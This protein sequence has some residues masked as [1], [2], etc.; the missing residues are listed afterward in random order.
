[1]ARTKFMQRIFSA[2]ENKESEVLDQIQKDIEIALEDGSIN[3]EEYDISV[4][5]DKVLLLDK[6]NNETTEIL[7]NAPE[8]YLK[9]YVEEQNDSIPQPESIN[10]TDNSLKINTSVKWVNEL[11]EDQVGILTEI[12]GDLATVNQDGV[13]II[14]PVGI[15]SSVDEY[16][17]QPESKVFA[18]FTDD[19]KLIMR[20]GNYD[21]QLDIDEEIGLVLD[22]NI[23]FT[24]DS[25]APISKAM[26][27]IK[28]QMKKA[29]LKGFSNLSNLSE[30]TRRHLLSQKEFSQKPTQDKIDK[31][32]RQV[33]F[34]YDRRSRLKPNTKLWNQANYMLLLEQARLDKLN[35][36]IIPVE[37][38]TDSQKDQLKRINK[39]IHES[40]ID[41]YESYGFS[42]K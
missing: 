18:K 33:K 21:I 25:K 23:T 5:D 6:V 15:I 42:I 30:S 1:M 27:D 20:V 37:E 28:N 13:S 36:L 34:W 29:G 35:I 26:K 22:E 7:G 2:V 8:Y 39:F 40:D 10:D 41:N 4:S 11:G 38:R 24:F 9:E 17:Q 14:V 12:N 19:G 31:K 16:K 3:T 32:K